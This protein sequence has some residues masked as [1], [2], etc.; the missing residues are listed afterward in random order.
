[1]SPGS[2]LHLPAE[3]PLD[4]DQI[5]FARI[6]MRVNIP[7]AGIYTITHPYGVETVNVTTPAVG[8]STSPETSA[9]VHRAISAAR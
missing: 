7:V 5:S 6:R 9:S 2:R 8:R 4:G 3:N 1:M